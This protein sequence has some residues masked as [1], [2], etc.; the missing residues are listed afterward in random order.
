MEFKPEDFIDA[1]L[2]H[3]GL[4]KSRDERAACAAN[5]K[6]KE[7]LEKAPVVYWRGETR[8]RFMGDIH[9]APMFGDTHTARLVAVEP[10]VRDTA[11]SLLREMSAKLDTY[12]K[13]YPEDKQL[14]SFRAR[15]AK[16]LETK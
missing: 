1:E 7:W 14:R 9:E 2:D 16:I 6:L 8:D 11:E 15:A 5:A 4:A 13:V 3:V 12:Q 10:I